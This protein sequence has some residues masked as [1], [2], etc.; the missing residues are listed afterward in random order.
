MAWIDQ[1]RRGGQALSTTRPPRLLA[2]MAA[3]L[4]ERRG[5]LNLSTLSLRSLLDGINA[6]LD[7]SHDTSRHLIA[8]LVFLRLLGTFCGLL[9][10]VSSRRS[11]VA[12]PTACTRSPAP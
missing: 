3:M 5:R 10:T 11:P 8:L 12:H 7:Q 2:P 6:R 9:C 1:F 4:G